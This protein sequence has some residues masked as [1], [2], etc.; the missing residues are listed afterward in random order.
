MASTTKT[1]WCDWPDRS[2]WQ[3]GNFGLAY[4]ANE[5]DPGY[6][7]FDD[8]EILH[9]AKIDTEIDSETEDKENDVPCEPVSSHGV[10]AAAM[11][12]RC[13]LWLESQHDCESTQLFAP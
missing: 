8:E 6:Q 3:T 13:L 4:T 9:D 12:S 1:C 2:H 7:T 5:A 11:F 10:E